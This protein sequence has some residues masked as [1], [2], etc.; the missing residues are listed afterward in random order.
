MIGFG[1]SIPVFFVTPAGWVLWFAS[2]VVT[3]LLRQ[4]QRRRRAEDT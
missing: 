2:P 1:L 4:R 3:G